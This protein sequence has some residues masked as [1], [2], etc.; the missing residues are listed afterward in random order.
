MDLRLFSKRLVI[1]GT[2]IIW[3]IKYLLRPFFSF[4][5]PVSFFLGIAP[6]LIGSFLLPFGACWLISR[7]Q[8]GLARWCR[9]GNCQQLRLF[10]TSAFCLLVVNEYLQQIRFFGRTFDYFDIL[11]S[12]LGLILAYGILQRKLEPE[13]NTAL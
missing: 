3:L 13:F 9:V 1:A 6:N 12:G 11:F 5:E 10:C 8:T 2:G 7:K 4:P